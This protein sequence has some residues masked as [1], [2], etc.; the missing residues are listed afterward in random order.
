MKHLPSK[1][2]KC[3]HTGRQLRS[4]VKG[5][6]RKEAREAM[7]NELLHLADERE[8]SSPWTDMSCPVCH[9]QAMDPEDC[10]RS[11]PER[12]AFFADVATRVCRKI[13]D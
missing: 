8:S 12:T 9:D 5:A 13:V 4:R 3:V 7:I 2:L 10:A 11:F 1:H 6:R